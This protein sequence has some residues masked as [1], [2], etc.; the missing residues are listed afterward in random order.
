M[1]KPNRE[2]PALIVSLALIIAAILGGFWWLNQKRF[3]TTQPAVSEEL[4][5]EEL[6]TDAFSNRHETTEPQP[7]RTTHLAPAFENTPPP[8][9]SSDATTGT[10]SEPDITSGSNINREKSLDEK[11]TVNNQ[12]STEP[13]RLTPIETYQKI[14]THLDKSDVYFDGANGSNRGEIIKTLIRD[15]SLDNESGAIARIKWDDQAVSSILFLSNNRVRLWEEANEYGGR[16]S[17]SPGGTLQI[18]MDKGA[19][20]RFVA[21][22]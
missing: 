17:W 21:N 1:T 19:M 20:F 22:D 10:H 13:A 7:Q 4:V 9:P 5:S 3:F 15:S 11:P 8:H 14:R 6:V 12:P 18:R 16:W 2:T